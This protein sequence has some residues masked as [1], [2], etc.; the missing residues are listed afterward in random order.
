MIR[1]PETLNQ[2]VDTIARFVRERLVPAEQSVAEN[3]AIPEAIAEEM[4]AMGLFDLPEDRLHRPHSQGVTLPSMFCPQLPAH[5]VRG[6]EMA[7]D[8]ASG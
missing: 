5:A 3:D 4:K 7:W 6:R 2:L 1:D 8:T